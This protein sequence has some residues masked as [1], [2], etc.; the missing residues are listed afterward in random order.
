MPKINDILVPTNLMKVVNIELGKKEILVARKIKNDCGEIDQEEQYRRIFFY[1]VL[2]ILNHRHSSV[3]IE[4]NTKLM[5]NYLH[6]SN[7]F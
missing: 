4:G 7:Q 6:H 2:L 5:L 3:H 1:H